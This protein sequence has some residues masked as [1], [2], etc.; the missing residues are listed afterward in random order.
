MLAVSSLGGA[1]PPRVTP[2]RGWHP[3]EKKL[4]ANLRRIVEKRGR[5]GKKGVR[6]NPRGGDTRVKA[7]ES[8]SDSDS[9]EQRSPGFSGKNRGWHLQLPPRVSP[10]LVTP[11]YV[12]NYL[13]TFTLRLS[14]QQ[15]VLFLVYT[16]YTSLSNVLGGSY[17][18]LARRFRMIWSTQRGENRI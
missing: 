3:K 7:I 5:T 14:W 18:I 11:L 12:R 6:W 15:V 2:F 8:D 17:W 16:Y 4:W 1:G 13:L 9:D 10:T